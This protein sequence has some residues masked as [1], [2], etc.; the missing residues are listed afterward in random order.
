MYKKDQYYSFNSKKESIYDK[1]TYLNT[2]KN[3]ILEKMKVNI[4]ISTDD[5]CLYK[6]NLNPKNKK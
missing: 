3:R 6:N 2:K 1:I 4:T 5:M